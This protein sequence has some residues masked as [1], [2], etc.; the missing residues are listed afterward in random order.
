MLKK[1]RQGRTCPKSLRMQTYDGDPENDANDPKETLGIGY[2]AAQ[3]RRIG[4]RLEASPVAQGKDA[5][6]FP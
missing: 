1:A 2:L 5:Q 4:H 6:A 3:A